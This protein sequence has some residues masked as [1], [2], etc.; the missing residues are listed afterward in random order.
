MSDVSTPE[1][2]WDAAPEV[3]LDQLEVDDELARWFRHLLPRAVVLLGLIDGAAFV[4]AAS[5]PEDAVVEKIVQSTGVPE[6]DL[7]RVSPQ[8]LDAL[9]ARLRGN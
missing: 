8:T 3:P 9:H 2:D 6:I 4:A 7:V 5:C 1:L